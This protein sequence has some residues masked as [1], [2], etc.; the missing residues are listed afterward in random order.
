MDRKFNSELEAAAR[1][2]REYILIKRQ[3]KPINSTNDY[4][5][6]RR[7]V[8]RYNHVLR[9]MKSKDLCMKFSSLLRWEHN[10]TTAIDYIQA[11]S[12]KPTKPTPTHAPA[13]GKIAKISKPSAEN[14]QHTKSSLD[15][16]FVTNDEG[17][18]G[19]ILYCRNQFMLNN[20]P[21]RHGLSE[22][23]F[24]WGFDFLSKHTA[25]LFGISANSS[26]YVNKHSLRE[27]ILEVLDQH[28]DENMR[29]ELSQVEVFPF[30]YKNPS[31]H[32]EALC[33][34]TLV[35]FTSLEAM[36]T[37]FQYLMDDVIPNKKLRLGKHTLYKYLSCFPVIA[38]H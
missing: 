34:F 2:L 13:A 7:S 22:Q 10:A 11:V 15:S 12:V 32:P 35:H 5:L 8:S 28:P 25:R 26:N 21:D 23:E 24:K 36:T 14:Y 37:L 27:S 29:Q 19:N 1:E 9:N 30:L 4:D 17:V 6:F 16:Y 33:F 3:G 20:F 18:H 31:R 38:A